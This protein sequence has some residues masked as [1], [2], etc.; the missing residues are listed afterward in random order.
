[1]TAKRFAIK[2]EEEKKLKFKNRDF[3]MVY[4]LK[5]YVD[6]DDDNDHEI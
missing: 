6:D 2:E 5:N 4:L 1:M 3:H